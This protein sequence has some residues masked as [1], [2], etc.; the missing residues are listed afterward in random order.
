MTATRSACILLCALPS[1]KKQAVVGRPL[2]QT[3]PNHLTSTTHPSFPFTHAHHAHT[4]THAYT[5]ISQREREPTQTQQQELERCELHG[6][7]C[8]AHLAVHDDESLLHRPKLREVSLEVLSRHLEGEVATVELAL[9]VAAAAALEANLVLRA[10][11]ELVCCLDLIESIVRRRMGSPS[12]DPRGNVSP[13]AGYMRRTQSLAEEAGTVY[14]SQ[15][16]RG[17]PR[18]CARGG[19]L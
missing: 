19:R 17:R 3:V 10:A 2:G 5:Q 16:W 13:S 15:S 9:G 1:G 6:E 18:W 7:G 11:S 8:L 4:P 14:E 12:Q